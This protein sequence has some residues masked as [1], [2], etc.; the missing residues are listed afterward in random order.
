MKLNY[1]E[2]LSPDPLYLDNVGGILSPKLVDISAIGYETYQYYLSIILMDAKKF[3]AII[4]QSESYNLF[5]A[6]QKSLLNIFDL[7]TA[8]AQSA[9]L[10][11]KVLNF[12]IKE[13]VVYSATENCFTVV[14]STT[15]EQHIIGK[16]TNENYYD[17]CDLICKR[18]CMKSQSDKDLSKAKNNK[19]LEIMQKLQKGRDEREK[20]TKSDENMDIGN[21]VSAVAAKSLSLNILNIWDLTIYQL[22]DT[23]K[24]LSANS[25]YNIQSLS[26]AAWGNKDGHFDISSWYRNMELL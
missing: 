5:S 15:D 18:N 1:F 11:Q 23:F 16:I 24:R 7:L 4:G 9:I 12:F 3:M 8:D 13:D 26:T 17:V 2:L 10:L 19:A 25:V 22:W 14:D 6:E 20:L 21:I